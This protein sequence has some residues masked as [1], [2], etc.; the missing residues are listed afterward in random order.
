VVSIWVDTTS[1]RFESLAAEAMP[2]VETM[3]FV[4]P[5]PEP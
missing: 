4:D 1:D 2:I 5:S 3:R